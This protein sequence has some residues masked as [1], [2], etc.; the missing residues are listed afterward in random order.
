L[1]KRA[2]VNANSQPEVQVQ[3]QNLQN[4]VLEVPKPAQGPNIGG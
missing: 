3:Q 2:Q 1:Q 4:Q